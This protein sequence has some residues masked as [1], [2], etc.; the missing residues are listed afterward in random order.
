V[1]STPRV[2]PPLRFPDCR[3]CPSPYG[4]APAASSGWWAGHTSPRRC[5]I[6]QV[7]R[8]LI[9]AV[10][11]YSNGTCACRRGD[12][13]RADSSVCDALRLAVGVL[14]QRPIRV[15][16]VSPSP[17][18]QGEGSVRA[19]AAAGACPSR[20]AM[21]ARADVALMA[22]FPR[23]TRICTRR[24]SCTGWTSTDTQAESVDAGVAT[25]GGVPTRCV[26]AS[27][28]AS[29]RLPARRGSGCATSTPS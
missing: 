2:R 22:E 11:W 8:R 20:R 1:S 21:R 16:C 29:S 3:R 12:R 27:R 24:V 10:A 28:S 13:S 19:Q 15:G 14:L 18:D 9:P 6:R 4:A 23:S 25:D 7:T 17:P 26:H 5:H